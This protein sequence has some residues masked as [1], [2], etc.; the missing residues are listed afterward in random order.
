MVS[1]LPLEANSEKKNGNVSN[2]LHLHRRRRHQY[3][4]GDAGFDGFMLFL[5]LGLGLYAGSSSS[6]KPTYCLYKQFRNGGRSVRQI[7]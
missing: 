2:Q 5:L 4:V 1:P 6:S 3:I 7:R